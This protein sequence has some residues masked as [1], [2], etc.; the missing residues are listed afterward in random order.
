MKPAPFTYHRAETLDM[1]TEM[2]AT[3]GGSGGDVRVL[4]G[5]Q[6]LMPMMNLR[7]V[8]VD[9]VV[10][11]N[12]VAELAGMSFDGERLRLGAMTR[13]RDLLE[14]AEVRRRLPIIAEALENVGHL[15]TRNRGTI[16]GSLAHMDP[17]AELMGLAA[18]LD[19]TVS[20]ASR[21]GQRDVAIA[22]YPLA[23]MTPCL[24]PDEV[25]TGI[26]IDTWPAGHGWDF[27]EF[28][29]R[30]GDFAVAGVGSLL[31]LDATGRIDRAAIVLIGVDERPI[32]LTAAEGMLVGEKPGDDVF[33][34]AG[35]AARA[36]PM[37][38]DALV[39]EAY[40]Q[41]LAGVLVAR[42]LDSASARAGGGGD[43]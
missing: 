3:L 27:R 18:L 26:T 17:A 40:R 43:V 5:G 13:Q 42:S 2:L 32:R 4:A 28:A 16:G 38:A 7:Y 41:H 14:H 39:G 24:E 29:Q 33:G 22:D 34:A 19:A 6:S 31:T 15:Q 21:R 23:Y 1:A 37:L 36:L 12:P 30:H 35:A 25:L 10:D 8:A 20:M 9:H 11:L